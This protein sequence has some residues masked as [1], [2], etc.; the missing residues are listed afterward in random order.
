MIAKMFSTQEGEDIKDLSKGTPIKIGRK[1]LVIKQAKHWLSKEELKSL[2]EWM[3]EPCASGA[4][5]E[6]KDRF[7]VDY[8]D[9]HELKKLTPTACRGE[10][11]YPKGLV[12]IAAYNKFLLGKKW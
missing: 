4:V 6:I 7:R 8:Q 5:W 9:H 2:K 12:I 3:K 1:A 10:Y 11:I